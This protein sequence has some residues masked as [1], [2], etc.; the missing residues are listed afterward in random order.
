MSQW[1]EK[2]AG[3]GH[4]ADEP[5]SHLVIYKTS[6]IIYKL[7]RELVKSVSQTCFQTHL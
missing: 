3:E 2:P 1:R 7:A 4:P 5:V 6:Q